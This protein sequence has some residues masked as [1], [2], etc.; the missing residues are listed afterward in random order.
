MKIL[1]EAVL[2]AAL[3]ISCL[4][5]A[6]PYIMT[7]TVPQ[8]LERD[9]STLSEHGE[10]QALAPSSPEQYDAALSDALRDI[11]AVAAEARENSLGHAD[12]VDSSPSDAD[13]EICSVPENITTA[14]ADPEAFVGSDDTAAADTNGEYDTSGEYEPN[15]GYAAD[16]VYF[17]YTDDSVIYVYDH[18]TGCTITTTLGEYVEG[19]CRAE[20]P[21]Y[22]DTEALRAQAIAARSY[23]VYKLMQGPPDAEH[24]RACVCNEPSH[25][26]AYRSAEGEYTDEATAAAADTRNITV[27]YGGMSICAA[28]HA[29]SVGYTRSAVDVWGGNAPYL[30]SVPTEEDSAACLGHGVGMSQ[31]GA[32][33]MA[34]R[35]LT[36]EEILM[37]YYTG[38]ELSRL[39]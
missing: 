17:G 35:G 24:G 3:S 1:I 16:T 28:W 9:T 39:D 12:A 37:H 29:R 5:G 11:T 31:Y 10:S 14:A 2:S 19:V 4:C 18:T 15:D 26:C 22:F 7:S 33:A 13:T 6:E 36:A 8:P 23:A 21:R 27:T 32:L 38:C 20:M 30:V 34:Q 25:C